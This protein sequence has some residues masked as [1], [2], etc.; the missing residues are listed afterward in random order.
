MNSRIDPKDE[1]ILTYVANKNA[2]VTIKQVMKALT[3]S[4]THAK[5]ALDFFVSIGL[6]ESSKQGSIRFYKTK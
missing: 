3:I 4:E 6:A 1:K 2:P 5:R